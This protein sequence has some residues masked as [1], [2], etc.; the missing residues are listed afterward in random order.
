[1]VGPFR[2]FLER[3]HS[4]YAPVETKEKDGYESWWERASPPSRPVTKDAGANG[5]H[6]KF[7][8]LPDDVWVTI[9]GLLDNNSVTAFA[10]T[11]QHWRRL[12]RESGRKLRT[13]LKTYNEHSKVR[14]S[15]S[16]SEDWF[17]WSITHLLPRPRTYKEFRRFD[18]VV[19]PQ[20]MRAA[21]FWG[22]LSALKY[23]YK[24]C[25]RPELDDRYLGTWVGIYAVQGRQVKVL[26]WLHKKKCRMCEYT[27]AW[28]A[29][30]GYL[31]VLQLLISMG[32][33]WSYRTC[34]NAAAN[35]H[36]HVLRWAL[37]NGCPNDE[38]SMTSGLTCASAAGYGQLGALV[39]AREHGCPWNELT[40]RLSAGSGQ[41]DTLIWAREHGCPWDEKTCSEAAGGGHLE[42]LAWARDNGCPWDE[43]MCAKAAEGGHLDAL[44]YAREMGCRWNETTCTAAAAGG[45]LDVLRYARDN[46][47]P[48]DELTTAKA[49]WCGHLSVL[50]WA[51]THECPWDVDQCLH[52][53]RGNR[54]PDVAKWIESRTWIESRIHL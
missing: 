31:D 50:I 20:L 18:D 12:Q 51:I 27:C 41:L 29:Q 2:R 36:V 49:A 52:G 37:E 28:A 13:D 38:T 16:L 7:L 15:L 46:G 54:H 19:I 33:E 24:G 25:R 53:A 5:L 45:H 14:P 40:C 42:T 47:C 23:W 32:C 39:F 35:G 10:C 44:R 17:L 11:C 3:I 1:M 43:R 30:L 9:L 22:H 4:G 21:A 34:V 8:D 6:A 48:W 26:Q